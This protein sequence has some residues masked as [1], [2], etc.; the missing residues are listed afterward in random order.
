VADA[1]GVTRS[2]TVRLFHIAELGIKTFSWSFLNRGLPVPGERVRVALRGPSGSTR[3][4]NDPMTNSVTGPVDEFCLVVTQRRNYLDTTL[5]VEGDVAR[6]WMEIAQ[7]FA[8]PP[9]PGRNPSSRS[10]LATDA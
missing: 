9:G 5:V 4:W 3:V 10:A 1:V 2:P 7:A 8:G 6:T